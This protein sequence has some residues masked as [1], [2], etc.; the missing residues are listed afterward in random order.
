M[1]LLRRTDRHTD[2]QTYGRTDLRTDRHTDR[3]TYEL[4]DEQSIINLARPSLFL[5]IHSDLLS[6]NVFSCES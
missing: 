1:G 6:A 5:P 4:T 2:R 3:Q